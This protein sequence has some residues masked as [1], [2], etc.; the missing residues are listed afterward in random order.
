MFQVFFKDL[1]FLLFSMIFQHENM[2]LP[3]RIF[4]GNSREVE[5]VLGR[6]KGV[7]MVSHRSIK[8]VSRVLQECF[9]VISRKFRGCFKAHSLAFLTLLSPGGGAQRPPLYVFAYCS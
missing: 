5:S 4:R 1:C 8:Y 9:L 3:A 2:S 6:L 7:S